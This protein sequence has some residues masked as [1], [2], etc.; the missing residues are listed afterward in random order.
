MKLFTATP[1]GFTLA[2]GLAIPA[3]AQFGGGGA[4][5]GPFLSRGVSRPL[6]G[7]QAGEVH[8]G[9]QAGGYQGGGLQA[10]Q[11]GGGRRAATG[12]FGAGY[13]Y[14][15]AYSVYVPSYFDYAVDPSYAPMVVPPQPDLPPQQIYGQQ[16]P[17]PPPVIIN[18]YF[19]QG[20]GGPP[21]TV[22][23]GG[24]APPQA[25]SQPP[26]PQGPYPQGFNGLPPG[27]PR[28][29]PETFYVIAFKDRSFYSALAYWIEGTTLHY[30][31]TQNTHNQAA[32]DLIDI[33]MTTKLN[34][35]QPVPFSI[36]PK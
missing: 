34:Q 21:V 28:G 27:D 36:P 24:D 16:A 29:L 15:F 19:V 6:G 18:Q 32:L 33:D 2:V 10:R 12:R 30:V 35:N 17:P 22:P 7:V 4:L 8:G 20:P 31:T 9:F 26:Y 3:M 11:P 14:P 1:I 13:G 23:P 25:Y 5:G